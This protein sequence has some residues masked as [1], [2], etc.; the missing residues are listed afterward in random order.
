MELKKKSES[1]LMEVIDCLPFVPNTFMRD[2]WTTIGNTIYVPTRHDHDAGWGT[3]VWRMRHSPTITHELVHVA[4]FK[5]W[6]LPL[7]ALGYIG[8]TPFLLPFVWTHWSILVLALVLAPLSCGLAY[9][10]WRIERAAYLVNVRLG[11]STESVA[12]TLWHNYFF[13]WP[14][15]LV[16]KSLTER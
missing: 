13:C 2:F 11:M 10:R 7:M 9:F 14:K 5:K 12:D 4:Q 1:R 16:V 15:K 8:P 6:T 3:N